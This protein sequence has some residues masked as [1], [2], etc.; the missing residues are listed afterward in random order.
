MGSAN[1][2]NDEWIELKNTSDETI[3]LSGWSLKSS[4]AETAFPE[5]SGSKLKIFL[6]GSL[7]AGGLYLLERT[8]DNSVVNIKADIIYKG[9]L[10][11]AGAKLTLYDNLNNIIDETDYSLGWSKGDN[12]TK[13]TAER[14]DLSAWPTD[15]VSSSDA[16]WQT[17]KDPNGTPREANSAGRPKV[18]PKKNPSL[19]ESKKIDNKNNSAL[20]ATVAGLNQEFNEGAS[21]NN[22]PLIIFLASLAIILVSGGIVLFLKFKR[23]RSS[24]T[25]A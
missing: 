19:P 6:K 21:S 9:A 16:S 24:S 25:N 14:I 17:S 2:A 15:N 10:N 1:S 23:N 12:A 8:D 22:N 11:N 18:A 7:E 20:L 13:Q 5:N 3:N 4:E